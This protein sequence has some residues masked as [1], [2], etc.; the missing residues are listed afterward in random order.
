MDNHNEH[1][2]HNEK[3]VPRQEEDRTLSEF[4]VPL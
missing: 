3:Q 1:N 4:S 2:G